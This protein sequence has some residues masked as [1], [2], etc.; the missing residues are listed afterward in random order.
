MRARVPYTKGRMS[1]SVGTG[2]SRENEQPAVLAFATHNTLGPQVTTPKA[3]KTPS[4][5]FYN[6]INDARWGYLGWKHS[7]IL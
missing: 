1:P 6:E 5:S 3:A 2:V 7:L 4:L